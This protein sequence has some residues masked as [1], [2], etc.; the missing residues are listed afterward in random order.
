MGYRY[1]FPEPRTFRS[2]PHTQDL[3]QRA[4][5]LQMLVDVQM[6]AE[7]WGKEQRLGALGPSLSASSAQSLM[8]VWS[9]GCDSAQASIAPFPRIHHPHQFRRNQPSMTLQIML[10]PPASKWYCSN[11]IQ[12]DR[13]ATVSW[14]QTSP[15]SRGNLR[16]K[17]R[18]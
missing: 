2:S 4:E 5:A 9:V 12:T 6:E 7:G 14:P 18:L 17:L 1:C 16:N 10:S 11:S 3:V 15:L 8:Q 13:T